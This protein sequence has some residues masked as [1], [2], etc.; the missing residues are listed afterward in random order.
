MKKFLMVLA[1]ATMTVGFVSCEDEI[2]EDQPYEE[3]AGDKD[4]EPDRPG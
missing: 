3:F 1:V 2:A 4:E